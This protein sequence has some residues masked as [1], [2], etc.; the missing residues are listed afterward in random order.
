MIDDN[1]DYK[2]EEEV[3]HD[4]EAIVDEE[5][6]ENPLQEQL[7][8]MENKYRRALADYQ[9]LEKRTRDDRGELI[10]SS[11]RDLL[12]RLLPVLDTLFLAQE[13]VKDEGI[14]VSIQQFLDMLKSEGVTKIETANKNFDPGI[15]EC[16][17]TAPGKDGKVLEEIRPGYMLYD[18]L[19][20]PVQVKVGNGDK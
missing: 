12:L 17:V 13:H 4:E 1:S 9:N 8:E 15:M 7:E 6:V 16:I 14:Q 18:R 19:L 20:R 2:P 3:L 5:L 11:N 10:K